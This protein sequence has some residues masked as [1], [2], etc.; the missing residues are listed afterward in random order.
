M[1]PRLSGLGCDCARAPMSYAD[2][3]RQTLGA[4]GSTLTT[5]ARQVYGGVT[6]GATAAGIATSVGFDVAGAIGAGAAAGSVVPI[7]GTAIG[8]IVGLLAS[9][10]LNHRTDPEVGNFNQAIALYKSNPTSVVNIANK[11]LVLAGLFDLLPG[12]IKGNIPIYKKYGRM[13]EQRFVTDMVQQIYTA[14][15]SGRITNSDT[16]LTVMSKV[17]QPW[18]DSWGFGPMTDA[19]AQMITYILIGMIADYVTG[20]QRAWYAVGGDFPFANLPPF[21]LP[22]PVAPPA[23]PPPIAVAPPVI[24]VAP[25]VAAP[26]PCMAPYQWNGTRCVLPAAPPAPV[27]T[28]TSCAAPYVWNGT[29]CVLPVSAIPPPPPPPPAATAPPTNYSPV[30]T[31]AAGNPIFANAQG[32]LYSW[33]GTAMQIFNGQLAAGNSSAAQ[34]QAALQNALSQG[35][36]A[37]QAAAA[38]L[39]QAQSAGVA[40][41]PQ[42]QQQVAAQ[43]DATQAAPIQPVTAGIGGSL[44]NT[45]AIISIAATV[46]GLMFATAHPAPR[47]GKRRRARAGRSPRG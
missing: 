36:S 38:A 18:I 44:G 2:A 15:Q 12:Q 42:L 29:Q 13:G 7:I 25:P 19:N 40:V 10:V 46:L 37:Q 30:G 11:Y 1:A 47:R 27:P 45:A 34:M 16:P 31:D 5:D 32:V 22:Q 8:A 35:Q 14:A 39:Q 6:T 33:T 9:G 24:P 21:S 20:N 43:V 17:V 26:A 41:T 23:P 4:L 28:A 3:K